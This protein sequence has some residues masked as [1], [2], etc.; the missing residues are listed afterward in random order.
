VTP[1]PTDPLAAFEPLAVLRCGDDLGVLLSH[2]DGSTVAVF[3]DPTVDVGYRAVPLRL[4][5]GVG[6][7]IPSDESRPYARLVSRSKGRIR[8]VLDRLPKP[9][10]PEPDVFDSVPIGTTLV[11]LAALGLAMALAFQ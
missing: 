3:P 6:F 8:A 4:R 10:A 1:T 7:V 5:R 2:R 11:F 9:E